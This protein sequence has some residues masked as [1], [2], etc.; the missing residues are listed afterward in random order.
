[1]CWGGGW[2][3]EITPFQQ[4]DEEQGGDWR[5]SWATAAGSV[6][7]DFCNGAEKWA[8]HL[9]RM[10]REVR[11]KIDLCYRCGKGYENRDPKLCRCQKY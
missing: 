4:K 8:V 3:G 1:M 5:F 2:G 7:E 9:D 10:S 11:E 6:G